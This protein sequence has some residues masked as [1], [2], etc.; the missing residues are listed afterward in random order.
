LKARTWAEATLTKFIHGA[1]EQAI[2]SALVLGVTGGLDPELL[3]AYANTG[4]LHV[5]AVSG[6]HVSILYVLLVWMMK[7]LQRLRYAPWML[8]ATALVVLWAYAFITGLSPSVLRAVIMFSFIVV[9]RPAGQSTNI[10]NTLAASAFCLLLCDPFMIMSVGF[11]LSYLAVLGIVYL[12]PPLYRLWEP[13]G[14]L[15]HEAWK[16]TSVS[17]AAQVATFALG[18]FYFHQFPGSFLLSNLVAIP[19][20]VVALVAGLGLL[21]FSTIQAA[22]IVLGWISTIAIKLL[23]MVMFTLEALP[24]SVVKGIYISTLQC[25]LI[26]GGIAVFALLAE[27]KRFYYVL[28]ALALAILFAV[29]Q[30]HHYNASTG[31]Q[32]ITVYNV[33]GHSAI[34][35]IDRGQAWFIADTALQHNRAKVDFYIAPNRLLS[36]VD[37]VREGDHAFVKLLNGASVILWHGAL[38]MQVKQRHATLPEGPRPRWLVVSNDA[39]ADVARLVDYARHTRVILDSSNSYFYTEKVLAQAQNENVVVYSVRHR[40]AFSQVVNDVDI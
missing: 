28:A 6:L 33:Q 1:R 8:A 24:F 19:A 27:Y 4:T 11:Q 16:I 10:Y 25:W 35:L 18:I 36:G 2:A 9:S 30:W 20:S 22:A 3:S 31:L 17:I 26:L 23:N 14:W 38:V 39:L 29:A 40:G 21:A 12:H 7:P 15:W 13:Q 34:D 32:K 5:L 37:R